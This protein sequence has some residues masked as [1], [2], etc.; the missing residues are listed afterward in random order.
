MKPYGFLI[1]TTYISSKF[2]NGFLYIGKYL[3]K[4]QINQSY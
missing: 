2:E 3:Y 4:L 1:L